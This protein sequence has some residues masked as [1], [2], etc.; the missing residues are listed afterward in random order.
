MALVLWTLI[1]LFGLVVV[2]LAARTFLIIRRYSPPIRRI[3]EEDPIFM[4]AE[5]V[6][7]PEAE[8]VEFNTP[9]GLT[10]RGSYLATE[11]GNSK[12]V[13]VFCHEFRSD[14]WSGMPYWEV[15]HKNGFDIFAFDFR[16]HGESDK[17]PA[18]A[19]RHWV[20]NYE[21]DDLA[22]ALTYLRSRFGARELPIGL[23]GISR[24]GGTAIGVAVSN[25]SVRCLVTDGAFPTHSTMLAYMKKW[26]LLVVGETWW[27]KIL[28]SWYLALIRDVVL[29]RIGRD[30]GCHFCRL[31]RCI[32][33]LAPRPILMI[34]GGRDSYIRPDIARGFYECASDPKELWIVQGARHNACLETASNEY[35][36]RVLQFFHLHLA[37][38]RAAAEREARPSAHSSAEPWSR[39]RAAGGE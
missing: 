3:F 13:V 2:V 34:H 36:S 20:T 27:M 25:H 11:G 39:A 10:L 31:E 37:G 21:L 16:N 5:G 30:L 12:G 26:M 29:S 22:A 32:R 28:P 1:G 19:P 6:Q 7:H 38:E 18:Y 35:R 33:R 4:P 24:G 17:D 14:R 23:L 8:E 15:L 9:E